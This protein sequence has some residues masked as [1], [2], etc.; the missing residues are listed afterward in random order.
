MI[1]HS[2]RKQ[3]IS[4]TSLASRHRREDVMTTLHLHLLR[5]FLIEIS[6]QWRHKSGMTF[7]SPV[8]P[9][10]VEH[11]VQAQA[12]KILKPHIIVPL[13]GESVGQCGNRAHV[14]TLSW[15]V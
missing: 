12:Q 4:W 1:S 5:L 9:L 13:W 3:W 10:Y 14:M 15:L 6:I 7:K 2:I 11:H 8:I